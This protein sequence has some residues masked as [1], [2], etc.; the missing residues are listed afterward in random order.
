MTTTS[1]LYDSYD[2]TSFNNHGDGDNGDNN[3][4]DSIDGGENNDDE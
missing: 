1:S 2:C 3:N 4:D